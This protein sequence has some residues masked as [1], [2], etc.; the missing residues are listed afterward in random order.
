MKKLFVLV[1]LFSFA[2]TYSQKLQNLFSLSDSI[3][4]Y[5][6]YDTLKNFSCNETPPG[7]YIIRF[8]INNK[9]QVYDY[10][11]SDNSLTLLRNLFESAL[12]LS[13]S[14]K[15]SLIIDK[16]YFQQVYYNNYSWCIYQ[17]DTTVKKI[18]SI[19]KEV[20]EFLSNQ[21]IAIEN[22][23]D[24]ISLDEKSEVIVLNPVVINNV[25]PNRSTQK[26]FYNDY[27]KGDIRE[28]TNDKLEKLIE[29]VKR[30]RDA[31]AKTDYQ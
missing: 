22:S 30:R 5:F 13:L 3:K 24:R 7:I 26:Y 23:I 20:S 28:L 8:K 11:F 12:N 21:I 15:S 1:A 19:D 27:R 29:E 18:I 4:K 16:E 31:K 14:K 25:N 10:K 17:H 2:T 9:N 6:N